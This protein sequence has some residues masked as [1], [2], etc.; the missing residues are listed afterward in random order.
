[1]KKIDVNECDEGTKKAAQVFYRRYCENSDNKNFQGNECP[2]WVALPPAVQSH[3]CAVAM[4]ASAASMAVIREFVNMRLDHMASRPLMWASNK[5]SL[6]V[7]LILLA[8]MVLRTLPEMTSGLAQTSEL[9]YR[10]WGPTNIVPQAPVDT[11]WVQTAVGVTKVNHAGTVDEEGALY[12]WCTA[13][14]VCSFGN[15]LQRTPS[16]PAYTAS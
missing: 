15:W 13:I 14:P 2:A 11:A 16:S 4:L 6:G 5:E 10:L 12:V 8:E 1:M 3:W 9:T 7:Q